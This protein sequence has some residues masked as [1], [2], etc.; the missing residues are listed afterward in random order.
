MA[1][2]LAKGTEVLKYQFKD[3]YQTYSPLE[4][5]VKIGDKKS[6]RTLID[7]GATVEDSPICRGTIVHFYVSCLSEY[8]FPD[9]EML[10]LLLDH[11]S[12]INMREAEY[13]RTALVCA[14]EHM[15]P[16]GK[17]HWN[18]IDILLKR[19]SKVADE[20]NGITPFIYLKVPYRHGKDLK[21]VPIRHLV[22][23]LA[24]EK[25]YHPQTDSSLTLDEFKFF[26]VHL[27]QELASAVSDLKLLI[28]VS[29]V[30]AAQ[31]E[32]IEED[33]SEPESDSSSEE[34][35]DLM[36][37]ERFISAC[38]S[39]LARKTLDYYKLF[40]ALV[41][42]ENFK[43]CFEPGPLEYIVRALAAFSTDPVQAKEV[44]EL[45]QEGHSKKFPGGAL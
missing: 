3:D 27:N 36:Q 4:Y 1:A 7:F 26:A 18:V 37:R 17:V 23:Y 5:A 41:K 11:I 13:F 40:Q 44:L 24:L 12:D 21:K 6:A 33:L 15:K 14:L 25:K 10:D 9:L 29:E 8:A 19:G 34:D 42:E 45:L 22:E 35:L 20:K 31:P 32:L 28:S 38:Y 16:Y 30:L 2:I 39:S 43:E